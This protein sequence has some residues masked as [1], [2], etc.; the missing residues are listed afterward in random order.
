MS[1]DAK[2]AIGIATY[3]G[4]LLNKTPITTPVKL[5]WA[6]PSPIKDWF[7]LTK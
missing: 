6:N 1:I 2:I 5:I 3:K 4:L 7:E